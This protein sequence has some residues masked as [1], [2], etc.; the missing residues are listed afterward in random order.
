MGIEG[1]LDIRLGIASSSVD[2]VRIS[3]SRPVHAS[4]IFHGKELQEVLNAL[5]M[6]FSVCGTA[7]AC[8]GI[9]ASEQAL[10]MRASQQIEDQ[11]FC[12]VRMETLREQ[13]WRILLE[14]PGYLDETRDQQSMMLALAL[15]REHRQIVTEGRNPFL[16]P[17]DGHVSAP[18]DMMDLIPTLTSLL[19]RAVFGMQPERWLEITDISGIEEWIRAGS[20]LAARTLGFVMDQELCELGRCQINPLP[21]M[22]PEQLHELLQNDDFVA[23]PQW[24]GSCRETTSC[25][26][27]DSQLLQQLRSRYGNGLLVRLVARLTEIAQ[28]SDVLLPTSVGEGRLI[29]ADQGHSPGIGQVAAARGQLVHRV[30]LDEGLIQRYQILAP[31]EWNFHPQGV[32][33]TALATLK[34]DVSM[35]GQQAHLLITAI[36][37]CVGYELTV[38]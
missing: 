27:T 25:T 5:P 30:S 35:I 9:Q 38:H 18:P 22:E 15:Q 28:L 14:W 13:L 12:L 4:R 36:D 24:N 32:A 17:G 6:L 20:T 37:P 8:A 3:S 10:G 2:M 1:H 19:E 26:R 11:R 31:T 33:A 29:E 34:G 21:D 23:Q 16:L 7:Q